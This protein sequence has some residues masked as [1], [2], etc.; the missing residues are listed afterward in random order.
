MVLRYN[1]AK[2]LARFKEVLQ[3]ERL[4][5][6]DSPVLVGVSG[7]PDSYC[8]LDLLDRCGYALIV[9]HF[10]HLLRP[11][12][13]ADA[14]E[15]R[16]IAAARGLPFTLA[17][18]DA[19]GYALTHSLSVEEAARNLRYRFLFDQAQQAGAQAV[20]VGHTADDQVET[21]LMHLLRGTGLPGLKGMPFRALPNAWSQD[22]PLVRPLL[23]VWRTEVI[24][25]C[26]GRGLQPLQ[27][28]TN[29]DTTYFRNRLRN[30]LIPYLEEHN[31]AIRTALWRMARV[32]AG[33]DEVLSEVT[34]AAWE[35]CLVVAG[36][37]YVVLDPAVFQDQPLGVQRRLVRQAISRLRPGL[38]DLEFKI[39]QKALDF[40]KAPLS[41]RQL[42]LVAGLRLF[43][44]DG[45]LWLAAWEADLPEGDW[46]QLPHQRP[47][48]LPVPGQL[49]L[50]NEWFLRAELY[51]YLSTAREE[52]LANANPFQAWLDLE[53]LQ[54]PLIVRARRP[55]DRFQP[56][57]LAGHSMKISDFMINEKMPAR[58]RR[59]WPLVFSGEEL[60]WVPGYRLAE[61]FR[62][63]AETTGAIRLSLERVSPELRSER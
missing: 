31:P 34:Q 15:V 37:G 26:A 17:G 58:A 25:Y 19:A 27:D 13:E 51:P 44:E 14:Q 52:A 61:P 42:D 48:Y 11:E 18:A 22:I 56:L 63:A 20:A 4:L 12:A 16:R 50:P 30:E 5:V 46:P 45:R 28:K 35:A 47:L 55:G 41:T 36:Q 9:A 57:G 6:A 21:V 60:A 39:I 54:F 40:Q 10:N 49:S 24:A 33:D 43:M 29:L 38:R 1:F 32:L 62:L 59:A 23:G 8:L 7:G 53:K 2:M 3:V